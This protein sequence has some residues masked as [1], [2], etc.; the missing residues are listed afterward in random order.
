VIVTIHQPNFLPW[1]G[2]FYKMARAD[3]F[4]FL[5]SVPFAKG[6]YTNRVRIKTAAGPQWLTVPVVTRGRLGQV[7]AEVR[8]SNTLD[9]RKKTAQALRTNYQHCPHFQPH[10]DRI[11][12]IIHAA[13]D[14]L[15]DLN[16]QLIAYVA[17]QVGICTPTLR[18]SRMQ[19]RGKATDLLIAI[20]KELG[21]DTFLSGMGGAEYQDESAYG[22]AGIKLAYTDFQHPTYPQAFGEFV[23]G[24]S[25]V[26]LLFNCGPDA[27]RILTGKPA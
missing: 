16:I 26:D 6:S 18:A 11:L 14:G 12:E 27:M 21:A 25:I 15:A 5:D 19:A 10:A 3:R 20:A 23:P 7:I 8:C 13:G 1:L 17:G 22:R 24:L 4:V 9:W 2:Y